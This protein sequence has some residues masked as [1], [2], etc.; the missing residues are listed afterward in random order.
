[1]NAPIYLNINKVVQMKNHAQFLESR[2][3]YG[4]ATLTAIMLLA[5]GLL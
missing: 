1:M 3:W 2:L 5:F 4:L